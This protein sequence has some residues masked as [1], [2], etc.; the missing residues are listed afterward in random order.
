MWVI[1]PPRNKVVLQGIFIEVFSLVLLLP[2]S[3][4]FQ[5]HL[6]AT[7]VICHAP[8]GAMPEARCENACSHQ[9]SGL[10]MY[11]LAPSSHMTFRL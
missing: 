4:V 8:W 7:V 6:Y 9:A 5:P 1:V 2:L 10:G 3:L 11:P